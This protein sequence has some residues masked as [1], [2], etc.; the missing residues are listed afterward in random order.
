MV[1]TMCLG[2]KSRDPKAGRKKKLARSRPMGSFF[3]Q[4]KSSLAK[5]NYI[6]KLSISWWSY[7]KRWHSVYSIKALRWSPACRSCRHSIVPRS[8]LHLTV[9]K[10]S[11]GANQWSQESLSDFY[12][13]YSAHNLRFCLL[14][15]V[16]SH[17]KGSSIWKGFFNIS[18]CQSRALQYLRCCEAELGR[19]IMQ[20]KE[21]G[22]ATGCFVN[23]S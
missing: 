2:S 13:G 11:V 12:P 15:P 21:A 4:K 17:S 22:F 9:S 8:V 7:T 14:T 5:S 6:D 3:K 20:L 19:D 16:L 23:L 1:S 10:A 18:F